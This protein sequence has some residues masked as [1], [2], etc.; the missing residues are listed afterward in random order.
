M[1]KKSC[2]VDFSDFLL[3]IAAK[4]LEKTNIDYELIKVT[5]YN[6]P[7]DNAFFDFVTTYETIEHIADVNF[8]MKELSRVLKV[9]GIMVLTCPNIL[10]EPV[11]WLAAILNIHH[12]EGPHNFLKRNQLLKLFSDNNLRVLKENSTVIL[13]FNNRNFININEYLEKTLPA[14]IIRLVALRRSFILRKL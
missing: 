10:W 13:P 12:S 2:L 4:R 5:D 11:H 3:D 9:G 14:G 1:I 6:L 8:Y 7:F